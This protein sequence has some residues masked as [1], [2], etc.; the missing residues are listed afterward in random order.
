MNEVTI[1]FADEELAALR[2]LADARGLSVPDLV[3]SAAI[4]SVD[5]HAGSV[6]ELG[7]TFA[8]RH[9]ELLRRLGQ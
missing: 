5:A 6:R 8:A 2:D 1:G 4:D 3:R 9:A 7:A